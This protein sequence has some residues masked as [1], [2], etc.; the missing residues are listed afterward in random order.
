VYART[1]KEVA[2]KLSKI[3][4][5]QHNGIPVSDDRQTVAQFF[6]H[7]LETAVRTSVRPKTYDSYKQLY[8][9]HIKLQIG[10]IPLTKLRPQHVLQLMDERLKSGLS[11]RTVQY[12]RAVLR[13]ALG[14]AMKWG[15]VQRNVAALVDG[16]KVRKADIKPF[17]L[18]EVGNLVAQF[19]HE[20]IGPLCLTA[21]SLGL[22]QGEVLGLRWKDIDLD[23][24]RV[25]VKQIVT[26]HQSCEDAG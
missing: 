22:R 24:R 20:R 5:D 6:D 16:P 8:D 15:S 11:P 26:A 17:T 23:G 19:D 12:I 7:W 4:T 13:R 18:D 1:R 10:R 25:T 14:Q 21:L 2:K 3:V 9:H